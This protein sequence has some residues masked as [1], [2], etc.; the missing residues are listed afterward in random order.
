M[1]FLVFK[2]VLMPIPTIYLQWNLM[3]NLKLRPKEQGL[4]EWWAHSKVIWYAGNC[5]QNMSIF[6]VF[7]G[8]NNYFPDVPCI[9]CIAF[10]FKNIFGTQSLVLAKQVLCCL[11][12]T[13]SL[14]CFSYFGDGVSKTLCPCWLLTT[15]LSVSASQ[16]ARITSMSH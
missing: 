6:L 15:I 2:W 16:V 10:L 8:K 4:Q 7:T 3:N 9:H 14:F 12:H 11:S 13:S 1:V 5:F